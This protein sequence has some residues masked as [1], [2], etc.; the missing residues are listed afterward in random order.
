MHR[1]ISFAAALVLGAC[2]S[3][4][5]TSTDVAPSEPA[6]SPQSPAGPPAVVHDGPPG[7]AYVGR[8][9]TRDPAGPK[10]GWPGC[11]VIARFE[12]TEATVRLVDE[13]GAGEP[14][15]SEWDVSV[16]GAAPTKIVV[17]TTPQTYAV[18]GELE[19]GVHT[20]ELYKR[21]EAQVGVTQILGFDFGSGKLLAPPPP[22]ARRLEVIGDSAV[23]GFGV[24]GRAPC[25]P[26]DWAARWENFRVSFGA[27][28]GDLLDADVHGTAYSGK[29]LVKNI[30]RPT[31]R[32][33][34]A[35]SRAR[36][37]TIPRARSTWR[38][39]RRTSWSS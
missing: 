2:G 23:T 5:G 21:S 39:G 36:T 25:P 31:P 37:R 32:P 6:P 3:V 1:S 8:F 12:G 10:C 33:C 38:R 34:R 18:T 13:M 35:S 16:D 14:G 27:K 24:E 26:L 9:D 19:P 4:A 30:W 15:P 7:I 29:G 20:V 17:S 28:L 11:R 22:R